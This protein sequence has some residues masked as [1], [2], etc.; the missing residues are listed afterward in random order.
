M[1]TLSVREHQTC[2]VRYVME[3]GVELAT[4]YGDPE[5]VIANRIVAALEA[6]NEREALLSRLAA[7]EGALN[8]LVCLYAMPGESNFD[9]FERVAAMFYRETGLLAPGKDSS[10]ASSDSTSYEHRIERW[11][12]WYAERVE[13]A[14]A[15]LEPRTAAQ[16][17]EITAQEA[18]EIQCGAIGHK[19]IGG[20]D[21]QVEC[22]LCGAR[23]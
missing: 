23:S 20:N 21:E 17:A 6:V 5:A 2:S 8:G 9:R 7:L 13:N 12:A 22:I 3:D 19:F 16:P 11:E 4:C 15:L 14:R 10:A 18:A 1:P